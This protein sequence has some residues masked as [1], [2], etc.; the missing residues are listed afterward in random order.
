MLGDA[1]AHHAHRLG[2]VVAEINPLARDGIFQRRMRDGASRPAAARLEQPERQRG[3]ADGAAARRGRRGLRAARFD[4]GENIF[5]ADAPARAAALHR[6]EIHVVFFGKLPDQR[7]TAN[8]L[9]VAALR[10]GGAGAAAGRWS[11]SGVGA[12]GW[13]W[14]GRSSGAAAALG[15]AA[16]SGA[17]GRARSG[18]RSGSRR[19][20]RIDHGDHRLDRH[21]LPLVDLDF[22]QHAGRGRRNFRVHFVGR[23]FEQRLVALDAVARLLEPLA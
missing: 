3:S 4:R 21:G 14:S 2:F 7:G 16:F 18:G 8:F 15:A 1:L 22:L 20:C 13:R 6:G 9:A 10:R 19:A 23:N 17:G 5:L 11:G 12:A